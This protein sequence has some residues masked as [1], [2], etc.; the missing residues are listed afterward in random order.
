MLDED[1]EI[2]ADVIPRFLDFVGDDR[3]VAH[4][5]DFDIG[6]LKNAALRVGRRLSNKSSC[7][8][9]IGSESLAE[10][11]KLQAQRFG[12]KREFRCTW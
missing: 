11:E 7:F 8:I 2:L 5:A 3:L 6:F 12:S 10:T 1:G 9:E 4:N